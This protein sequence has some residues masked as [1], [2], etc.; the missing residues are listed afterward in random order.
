MRALERP[1]D[2]IVVDARLQL[3]GVVEQIVNL[4]KAKHP[5]KDGERP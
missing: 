4:L 3:I 5:V 1:S 2:A